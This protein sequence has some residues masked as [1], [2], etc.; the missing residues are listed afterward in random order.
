METP[1]HGNFIDKMFAFDSAV[2]RLT[3]GQYVVPISPLAPQYNYR[4]LHRYC[5][6]KGIDASQLTED[7]VKAFKL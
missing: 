7:E 3:G 1:N 2:D 6:E 4:D 5:Q